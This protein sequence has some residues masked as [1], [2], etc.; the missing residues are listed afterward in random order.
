MMKKTIAVLL[1]FMSIS[2]AGFGDVLL[3]TIDDSSLVDGNEIYSFI[4]PLPDDDDNWAVGR[5]KITT[6]SGVV[7]YLDIVDPGADINSVGT[8]YNGADGV[9]LGGNGSFW[10]TGREVQGVLP[11][12]VNAATL[13][14]IELGINHWIDDGTEEGRIDFELLAITDSHTYEQLQDFMYRQHD[15]NPPDLHAW[16]PI[17][18]HTVPEP[19]SALFCIFGIGLLML[20]RRVD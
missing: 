17:Y 11:S 6:G 13:F 14:A 3:W 8:I 15:I 20:T 9:W 4:S 1:A 19:S 12:D 10:G 16:N 2:L 5:V 7:K 18:Y